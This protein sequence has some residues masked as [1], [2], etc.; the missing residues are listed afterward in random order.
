MKIIL[1]A[2]MG[3]QVTHPHTVQ[4]RTVAIAVLQIQM[5]PPN[6]C[7]SYDRTC[8]RRDAENG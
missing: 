7:F 1:Q 8:R 3:F 4:A 5:I 2:E 6:P